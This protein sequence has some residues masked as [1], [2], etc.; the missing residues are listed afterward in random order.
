MIA[1]MTLDEI[2]KKYAGVHT[3]EEVAQ[4]QQNMTNNDKWKLKKNEWTWEGL[5]HVQLRGRALQYDPNLNILDLYKE[6][7]WFLP[8]K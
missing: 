5:T 4:Y 8:V 3:P 6:H 7:P 1:A 2:Q